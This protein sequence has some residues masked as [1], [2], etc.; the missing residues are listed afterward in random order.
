MS[1]LIHKIAVI[2]LIAI[3]IGTPVAGAFNLDKY[4]ASSAL[5]GGRWVKI[6]VDKSGLY[7]IPTATLRAWGFSDPSRVSVHGYGGQRISDELSEDL[8]VDDLPRIASEVTDAGI[9]FYGAATEKWNRSVQNYWHA[10]LNPY[11][12]VGYYFVTDSQTEPW[13]MGSIATP[14]AL[15]ADSTGQ[16]R[17]HHE[18]EISLPSIAGPIMLGEDFKTKRQQSFDFKTPGRIDKSVWFECQFIH[19]HP[20]ASAQ[21]AFT[22]DGI[23]V[24]R[25]SSDDVPATPDS[26]YVHGS[27]TAARHTASTNRTDAL[28]IGL[29]YSPKQDPTTA[30]LDYI[31]VNYTRRL[32]LEPNDFGSMEFWG[33]SNRLKL[34]ADPQVRLWDV[35]EPHNV[36]S[37]NALRNGNTLTW[38]VGNEDLFDELRH[39]V[40]WRPDATLPAP[41]WEG[42][43]AHQNLHGTAEFP[44]MVIFAE[45]SLQ[46]Q[47]RRIADLHLK[48][49]SMKVVVVNPF[50]VYNEFSSGAPDVS[51]LRKYL[52]MIYDRGNS[53][54]KPLR[55]V[56]LMG[57]PTLDHRSL[58][59]ISRRSGVVTLPSWVVTSPRHSLSDNESYPGD[60]LIAMLDDNSGLNKKSD[61]I[62][63]AV[64]RMPAR[65]ADDAAV[66]VDK[67]Y[68]YVYKSNDG[69]WTNRMLMLADDG[70]SGEHLIQAERMIS[71]LEN[72]PL[73]PHTMSKIY[74]DAY[75]LKGGKCIEARNEMFGALEQGVSWW[76]FT[77][78]A[79][80]HSWTGEGMLT[81]KD[82]TEGLY[83][84]NVP[85]VVASTCDFM[86]WDNPSTHS[87]AEYMFTHKAGGA[88]GM[89]SAARPV[90]IPNN[91]MFLSAIG[92]HVL[93]RES[94]G[95]LIAPAEVLRRAKNDIRDVKT[96]V[97]CSD[98]N[99][100]RFGYMG[101]PAMRVVVP[102]NI[103]KITS[104]NSIDPAGNEQI[105]IPALSEAVVE[106]CITTP[107]GTVMDS[108]FG[109]ITYE[110]YDA[111]E[112]RVT[113]GR[114]NDGVVSSYDNM[115]G[116]LFVGSGIV[117]DGHFRVHMFMPSVISQNF[118]NATLSVFAADENK[119]IRAAGVTRNFYVYGVSEPAVADTVAPSIR[120]MVLNHENFVEGE[121]VDA[122]PLL[123]AELDDNV[124]VNVSNA[125]V[126]HSISVTI[127]GNVTYNNVSS[128]YQP[129]PG[130]LTVGRLSYRLPSMQPGAHTA[131]LRVF[132]TSG[133]MAEREIA[134]NVSESIKPRI[135]EVFCDANPAV[136]ETNFYVRHDRPENVVQVKIEVFDLLGHPVWSAEQKGMSDNDLS[137]GVL[138]DL[139]DSGGTRVPRGIYLYRASI[140]TDNAHFETA[141]RRIAVAAE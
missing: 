46:A 17:V 90:L 125:G 72:S 74:V 26:H 33:V 132:D 116:R 99:R 6:S 101:D 126:G 139:R 52:K 42:A 81:Y 104:I 134:F 82:I 100:L 60:D 55:Y 109:P 68:R 129:V 38:T 102:S 11:T 39:Y 50:E 122:T 103:V 91:A 119:G 1:R 54:G 97:A 71:N 44:E 49:D 23:P 130:T 9:V 18:R 24:S 140:S 66:M 12:Q 137:A 127:D 3:A 47:A 65:N 123:M 111:T 34:E 105:I 89:I 58:L 7:L 70:D 128:Y 53:A 135:F 16:A 75:P 40:A 48:T 29:T 141:T 133:N 106:G 85:F 64:G 79:N 62:S 114:G 35:T 107:D 131:R 30:A 2:I 120:Q 67:L 98:D 115:G 45:P 93:D 113:L 14:G 88:I 5:A 96:G 43:V 80:D 41:K 117:R 108:F 83:F 118:R 21:L 10:E 92:R 57:R 69:V 94:D 112:S 27:A 13:Q 61:K 56:L 51:G 121:T 28:T 95:R 76:F 19:R 36:R 32:A 136:T 110:L 59:D 84:R 138:W 37:V 86:R 20:G 15:Q 77:G 8:Y 87:G 25:V 124:A 22:V 4:A 78:H 63:I 31:S 73:A